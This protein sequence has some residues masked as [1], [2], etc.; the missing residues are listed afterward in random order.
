MHCTQFYRTIQSTKIH[1]HVKPDWI[2]AL[3]IITKMNKQHKIDRK[4]N[5]KNKYKKRI[6]C[7]I[8]K[9]REVNR[10]T[11][12]IANCAYGFIDFI[13]LVWITMTWKKK[14]NQSKS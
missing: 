9:Q 10:K 7:S 14:Q 8:K 12:R 4:K 1:M 5:P 2:Q 6:S 11:I 3:C 13:D